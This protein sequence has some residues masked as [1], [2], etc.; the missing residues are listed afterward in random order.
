YDA[1]MSSVFFQD[2]AI[3]APNVHL[4]VGSGSHGE[5]TGEMIK[6]LEPVLAKNAPDWVLL[7]GDTNSTLAGAI[8]CAKLGI[9]VAHIEAGLRSFNRAMPEEINRIVADHLS[10]VL[11]CP[12][13]AAMR[14][15]ET[16]GLAARAVLCGDVMY[17]AVNHYRRRA[18]DCGGPLAEQWK[19]G[20]FILATVHRAE[21]TDD[22]SR[23]RH[24]FAALER[25]A[26]HI[27]PVVLPL[28]PRTKKML[29]SAGIELCH[30][31]VIRPLSYLEMLLL[32]VRA[33]FILTDSGGVQK[34]AYFAK[35]PCVTL[36]SETEWVETLENRCNILGGT[37]EDVIIEA[38]TA[39][40][41]RGPWSAAYGN[42]DAGRAILS[43]LAER[44][45]TAVSKL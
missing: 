44:R 38:V 12:T 8:V 17:D 13:A 7:Y 3:P 24:I 41:A 37:D 14:N 10:D 5:Q 18:E 4:G 27:C 21:N 40:V 34:E 2:L 36:R 30:V 9:P 11:F 28:H 6:R 15:L 1:E 33:R 32:E 25:I 23:L 20:T 19:P 16:E 42:G 45:S 31:T 35:V 39:D 26:R 29:V 43:A 22:P